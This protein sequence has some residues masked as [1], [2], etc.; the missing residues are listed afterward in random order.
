M[1]KANPIKDTRKHLSQMRHNE[2]QVP[3]RTE[4]LIFLHFW[5]GGAMIPPSHPDHRFFGK[6]NAMEGFT[7]FKDE[8]CALPFGDKGY[9]ILHNGKQLERLCRS[10]ATA[11]K[12]ISD[13]KRSAGKAKLPI[14]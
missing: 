6:C 7:M 2:T 12:F 13:C 8:Y 5:V 3:I 4:N 9:I 1:G 10:E 11:R 14:D